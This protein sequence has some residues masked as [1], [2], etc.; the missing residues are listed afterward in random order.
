M[1]TPGSQPSAVN[2]ASKPGGTQAGRNTVGN[3][4]CNTKINSEVFV[5]VLVGFNEP[6]AMRYGAM[7]ETKL[8]TRLN[9]RNAAP[10]CNAPAS[11]VQIDKLKT[12]LRI[13]R[14]I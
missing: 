10:N 3:N 8:P 12:N 13:I 11:S 2:R 5:S 7:I 1:G 6:A 4:R 9:P 14:K